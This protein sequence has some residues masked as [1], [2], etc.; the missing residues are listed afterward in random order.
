[1]DFSHDEVRRG[2]A[3][4]TR[5]QAKAMPRWRDALSRVFDPSA[6]H[7]T[8]AKRQV[9][10]LRH[11][12][13]FIRI[14]GVTVAVAAVAAA[15]GS[16]DNETIPVTG[17][18]P[19]SIEGD[20]VEVGQELDVTLLRTAQS[21]EVLAVDTYQ[22]ALDSGLVTTPSLADMIRLFQEQHGEHAGLLAATTRDAGGTPYDEPN[23]YLQEQVTGPA[24]EVL[25]TEE[26]VVTL[27]VEL[28]NT[29]AQTYV[30]ASEVLSTPALRQGIMSI[31]GV[32]ARHLAVLHTVQSQPPAPFP[33]MPRRARIDPKGY[34]PPDGPVTPT[35]PPSSSE[36]G[37][38]GTTLVGGVATTSTTAQ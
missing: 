20:A 16:D 35:T 36:D 29:A 3:G 12:R 30:F 19:T 18:L 13:E 22:T 31:G 8:T 21:I 38:T 34:V 2:L 37:S 9:L 25:A 15:C 17:T 1:M 28:E 23:S 32:E 24:V 27:A 33:L 26:E 5:A 14:G 7:S 6:R 10:G 11:R 4:A